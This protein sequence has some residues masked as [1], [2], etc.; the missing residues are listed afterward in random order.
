MFMREFHCNKRRAAC[1]VDHDRRPG[2][3]KCIRHS[4]RSH[5]QMCTRCEIRRRYRRRRRVQ[6]EIPVLQHGRPNKDANFLRRAIECRHEVLRIM[7]ELSTQREQKPLLRIL[8]HGL[9]VR[10][11]E[12][13]RRECLRIHDEATKTSHAVHSLLVP[14]KIPS[15]GRHGC[16]CIHVLHRIK[17]VD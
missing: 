17:V 6:N 14:I 13:I 9:I 10:H 16:Y 11:A 3:T 4:S 8:V 7:K 2:K 1:G 5:T 15:H 12:K